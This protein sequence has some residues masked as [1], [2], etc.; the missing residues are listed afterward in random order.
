MMED[1]N[2]IL[3]LEIV[4]INLLLIINY[5]GNVVEDLDVVLS[6]HNGIK[7]LVIKGLDLS[8]VNYSLLLLLANLLMYQHVGVT[9]EEIST[10]S[11]IGLGR[12]GI[13]EQDI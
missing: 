6:E 10:C 2:H 5:T 4:Y 1:L 8:G 12:L 9:K 11:S 3:G 7:V 13:R